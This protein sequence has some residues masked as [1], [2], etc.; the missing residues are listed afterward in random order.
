MEFGEGLLT[1]LGNLGNLASERGD[2]EEAHEFHRLHLEESRRQGDKRQEIRALINLAVGHSHRSEL[3][4]AETLVTEA[5][6]ATSPGEMDDLL[7]PAFQTRAEVCLAQGRFAEAEKWV[8][9]A[10]RLA[11]DVRW[12][13]V[14]DSLISSA[15]ISTEMSEFAKAAYLVGASEAHRVFHPAMTALAEKRRR[16]RLARTARALGERFDSIYALGARSSRQDI[17]QIAE[18]GLSE[19]SPPSS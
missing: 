18:I 13:V 15:E 8:D 19:W 3:D 12:T 17:R 10:I 14:A 6:E 9:S 4:A 2:A 7:A 1:V 16:D 5:I 11:V